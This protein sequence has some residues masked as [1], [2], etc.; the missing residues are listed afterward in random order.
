MSALSAYAVVTFIALTLCHGALKKVDCFETFTAGAKKGLDISIRILPTLCAMLVAVAVLQT[1]G[2]LELFIHAL[3]PFAK[4]IGLPPQVLPLAIV[5]PFSG[6]AAMGV[7]LGTLNTY[8]ADSSIGMAACIIMGSSETV[9]YTA[10]LYF[11]SVGVKKWRH[12]LPL[13]L[14]GTL[15][16][17]LMAA[18]LT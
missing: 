1:S 5:R 9:F 17:L 15:A 13:C 3:M 2:V 10:G 7:L 11:G 18:I 12:T 6:S 16:S 14:L 8:G 4:L